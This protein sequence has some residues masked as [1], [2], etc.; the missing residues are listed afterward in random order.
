MM[1]EAMLG[2]VCAAA[3]MVACSS[4][5]G[6]SNVSTSQACADLAQS[7]CGRIDA[8]AP[9]YV[10][11]AYGD[12]ATCQT[13]LGLTCQPA[14]SATGVTATAGDVESCAQAYTSA[15]C[16]DVL[17]NNSPS[18]CHVHGSLPAG[19]PCGSDLQCTG[20]QSYCKLSTTAMCGVCSTRA[21]AGG[22]CT[23]SSD[24]QQGLACVTNGGAAGTCAAPGAA[25]ATCDATHPCKGDLACAGGT[26]KTPVEAGAACSATDDACD[27][28][29]GAYCNPT[30]M[31]CAQ[32][33]TAMAGGACGV[34]TG[35]Y[36]VCTGAAT[37]AAGTCKAAAADGATCGSNGASC[38]APATCINGSCTLPDPSSCH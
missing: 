38:L 6:G 22:A 37:C 23:Q 16:E 9:L 3:L 19:S 33:G 4:S 35:G 27:L 21:T 29:K 13:R 10:Q 8:C 14:L 30:G 12:V 34:V 26:C 20:D 32:V 15:S 36:A 28:P 5:S 24:C 7:L 31:V 18:A 1:R 11:I 2:G 25:G 17:S